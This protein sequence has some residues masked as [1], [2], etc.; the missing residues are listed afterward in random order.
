ES[1]VE[2]RPETK[3]DAK[4]EARTEPK[5]DAPQLAAAP[6]VPS[7]PAAD[8]APKAGAVAESRKQVA[9]ALADLAP[10]KPPASAAVAGP[11]VD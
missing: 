11:R 2:S 9:A 10:V 6:P 5:V 7:A 8:A 1:R 3:A 4:V